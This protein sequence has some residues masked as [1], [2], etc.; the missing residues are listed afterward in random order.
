MED[1]E[2]GG[3]HTNAIYYAHLWSKSHKVRI[4]VKRA[5]VKVEKYGGKTNERT[6]KQKL[7]SRGNTYGRRVGR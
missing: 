2:D 7:D 6:D 1:E 3:E 4:E 5:K